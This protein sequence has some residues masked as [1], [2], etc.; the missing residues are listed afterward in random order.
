[1][2]KTSPLAH[3]WISREDDLESESNSIQ[4][5][6]ILLTQLAQD[7]GYTTISPVSQQNAPAQDMLSK[8]EQQYAAALFVKD[9]S[10]LFRNRTEADKLVDDFLLEHEVRLVSVGD[11]IDSSEGD[12]EFIF[13]RNW[14]NEQYAKDISKKRRLSNKV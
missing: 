10:R 2:Q 4:N 9:L 8:L 14:A 7:Y 11:S 12:D 5:Q 13:L 3:H 6:I 1:M